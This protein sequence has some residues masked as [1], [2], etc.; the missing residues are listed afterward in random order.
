MPGSGSWHYIASEGQQ[1]PVAEATLSQLVWSGTI[2]WHSLVWTQGMTAWVPAS[3]VPAFTASPL[4][5]DAKRRHGCLTAWLVLM[6][7]GN[8][9]TA[10][11][12]AD[13][14]VVGLPQ[15]P[16]FREAWTAPVLGALGVANV[17]F[18]IALL[19]WKRWGFY[20][21]AA[22]TVAAFCVNITIGLNPLLAAT[23]LIAPALLYA[24]L[25]VGGD[26]SAW[27]LMSEGEPLYWH[28]QAAGSQSPAR[29][30][31]EPEVMG[32]VPT[33]RLRPYDLVWSPG[34]PHWSP[35][36]QV[37]PF[38]AAFAGTRTASATP[39]RM[40]DDPLLRALLPVGRSGWAIASGYLGLFSVL[41]L[42][43]PFALVTGVVA[44]SV[45][46][47]N[48]AKHGMGRAI[49]GIVMGVLGTAALCA[50]LW[51]SGHQQP[52]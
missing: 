22:T 49:F 17:V 24:L 1:G 5:A 45:I 46:R 42:P 26:Q 36:G 19:R 21:F 40:G 39:A 33:G 6:A 20:G 12:Y 16:A 3:T 41:L 9:L 23:V 25:M 37:Q 28:V 13:L 29:P 4:G 2:P 31:P 35:A 52:I 14:T 48:P 8:T 7:A 18:A 43:A 10:L 44:I 51:F 11:V 34:M 38:A 47:H 27:R 15:V 50:L 32:W 30:M